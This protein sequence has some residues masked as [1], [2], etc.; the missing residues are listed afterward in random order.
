M[1]KCIVIL[2][3]LPLIHWAQSDLAALSSK[4]HSLF[5]THGSIQP[6]VGPNQ[7]FCENFNAVPN[8][9]K[10]MLYW[11]GNASTN[12]DSFS[13][14]KS[15]DGLSFET[16]ANIKA[17]ETTEE[18]VSYSE[19]DYHPFSGT[20]FYRIKQTDKEGNSSYSNSITVKNQMATSDATKTQSF[21]S[22]SKKEKTKQ[23]LVVIL[24]DSGVE[25]YSKL[26]IKSKNEQLYTSHHH[27]KLCS[28]T[29]LVI[30]SSN[31]SLYSQKLIIK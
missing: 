11:S 14:E 22:N 8:N 16:L 21:I 20:S 4:P 28:G 29:Y 13:I 3:V 19:T 1:K 2:I 7:S 23:A 12:N 10:V 31:N 25:H 27:S 17:S 30:A 5:Y 24:D 9:G 26:N 15:G 18:I 6:L